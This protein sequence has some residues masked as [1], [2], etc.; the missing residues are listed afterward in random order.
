MKSPL[1]KLYELNARI[2]LLGV[3]YDSCTS[4]HLAETITKNKPSIKKNGTALI[5]NGKR[6]WVEFD[7][8]DYN[9]DDFPELGKSYEEENNVIKGKIGNADCILLDVKSGVDFAVTWIDN[10]RNHNTLI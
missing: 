8:P 10:N 3:G 4:F 6:Q 9:S 5:V 2:L 1:G 7:G